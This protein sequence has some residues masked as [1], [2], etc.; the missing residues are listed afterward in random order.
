M[1]LLLCPQKSTTTVEEEIAHVMNWAVEN[2]MTVN[3]VKTVETVF[4]RPNIGQDL[5]PLKM[6]NVS[7]VNVAKLLGVYLRHDL[8]V[9]QHVDAIVATC[10]QRFYLL[11]QLK[12][13]GLGISSLHTIFKAIVLNK[14]LYALPVYYEYLTEEQ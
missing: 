14:I 5:L 6:T 9:S 11:A 2:R 3:L 1:T 7:R 13:Q 10:S 8:N 12:K 4:H